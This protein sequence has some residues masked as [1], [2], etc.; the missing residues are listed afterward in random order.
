MAE[1]SKGYLWAGRILTAL[2]AVAFIGSAAMKLS[3]NAEFLKQWTAFGFKPEQ[4]TGVGALELVCAILYAI[5]QTS[6]LGAVLLTAYMG[7]ATAT[8]VRIGE[9][10]IAPVVLGVLVW[11]GL[12]FRDERVRALLP[13]RK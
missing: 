6:G 4:A 10:F 2:P 9:P 11:G 1:V 3:G 7:G 8:H 5:P 13:L 12:W